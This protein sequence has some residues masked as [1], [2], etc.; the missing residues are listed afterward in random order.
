MFI[1]TRGFT[2]S[3]PMLVKD[4]LTRLRASAAMLGLT[5]KD[6]KKYVNGRRAYCLVDRCTGEVL[7]SDYTVDTAIDALVGKQWRK[8]HKGANNHEKTNSAAIS[9]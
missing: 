4:K 8:Y 2:M 1:K 6:Q 9:G 7:H 5:F 3:K